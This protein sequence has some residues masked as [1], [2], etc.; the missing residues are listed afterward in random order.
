MQNELTTNVQR[1]VSSAGQWLTAN[2]SRLVTA[3]VLIV[4]GVGLAY[5]LRMFTVRLVTAIE[6]AIPGRGFHTE[7]ATAR[8]RRIANMLGALVFWGVLLFFVATAA[9]ALGLALLSSVVDTLSLFVPR[10]FA[11]VL[12][13]VTGA[14]MGNLARSA[15]TATAAGAG[16]AI[17]P[18]LGQVV[19]IAIIVASILIAVAEL[20]IDIALLT[21]VFSVAVAALLGGFALAF[22]LGAR[23]AVSNIIASHYVRQMFEVG[24]TARIGGVEGTIVELTATAVVL[25]VPDG[26]VIVPATQFAETTSVL[27]V[28]RQAP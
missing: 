11:A 7:T 20:G 12:I 16:T 26:R 2:E 15:V 27:V 19:R 1:S 24:Q 6:H 18:G 22:G 23:T 10:V 4:L 17:G 25:E 5:L 28:K 13:L 3:A 9:N 21:A 8:E 14:V